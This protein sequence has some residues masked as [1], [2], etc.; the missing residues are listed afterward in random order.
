MGFY[1]I[2]FAL[3]DLRSFS[4][5]WFWIGL[6]VVWSTASHFVMGVPF[7]MVQRARRHGGEAERD[8]VDLARIRAN[9]IL[10]IQRTAGPLGLGVAFF[11]L[12]TLLVLGFVYRIEFAQAIFLLAA[13]MTM[14]SAM[15]R[16]TAARI[17]AGVEGAEPVARLLRRQR[18]WTQFLGVICIFITAM[19]GMYQNVTLSWMVH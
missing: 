9:R 14:V 3:I 10:Y 2:V 11:L 12:T 7:D 4:N 19:W 15:S 17:G 1:H 8:L 18:F 13:P 5:L 16:R 6:A